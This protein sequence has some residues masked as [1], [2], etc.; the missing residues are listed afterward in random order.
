MPQTIGHVYKQP[1]AKQ[2]DGEFLPDGKEW[3]S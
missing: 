1:A 3:Q 2:Q